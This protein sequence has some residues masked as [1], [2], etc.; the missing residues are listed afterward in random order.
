M[1]KRSKRNRSQRGTGRGPAVEPDADAQPAEGEPQPW[2]TIT[3]LEPTAEGTRTRIDV[4]GRIGWWPMTAEMFCADLAMVDTDAIDV[5]INSPGGDVFQGIQIYNALRGHPAAINVEVQSVAASAA[6]LIAQAGDTIHM[7]RAA[8]MMVHEA[9]TG[10]HGPAEAMR[11]AADLL[12]KFNG[13]LAAVYA[14]HAGGTA[15]EWLAIM[16]EEQ[17]FTGPEAVDAGLADT[18]EDDGSEALA[19]E[20]FAEMVAAH[21]FV[22]I[23]GE[24]R[25]QGRAECPAPTLAER[26]RHVPDVVKLE[27]FIPVDGQFEQATLDAK[28]IAGYMTVSA[29]FVDAFGLELVEPDADED[30]PLDVAALSEQLEEMRAEMDAIETALRNAAPDL[31]PGTGEAEAGP[32]SA[33]T[34]DAIE[35]IRRSALEALSQ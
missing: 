17:W 6:S 23:E 11:E 3:A 7:D 2:Y 4:Q 19:A 15:A 9:R 22:L 35:T 34:D 14:A 10:V 33:A 27:A 30:D 31:Q 28:T 5:V 26:E 1:A 8:M 12:D 20:A 24:Y 16:A 13:Q 29:D 25:Y 32:D 18:A 21:D